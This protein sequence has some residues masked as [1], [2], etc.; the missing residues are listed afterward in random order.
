MIDIFFSSNRY[1]LRS[2]TYSRLRKR[3]GGEG[4]DEYNLERI[5]MSSAFGIIA[6]T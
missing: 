5:P 3:F 1:A 2:Y 6:D 4:Q